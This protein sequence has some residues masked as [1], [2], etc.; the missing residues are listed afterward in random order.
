[1]TEETEREKMA[2]NDTTHNE[3]QPQKD[4]KTHTMIQHTDIDQ[5]LTKKTTNNAILC[6]SVHWMCSVLHTKPDL[7]HSYSTVHI[8]VDV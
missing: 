7:N 4:P 2:S 5:N 6:L 1:M 3:K 8:K